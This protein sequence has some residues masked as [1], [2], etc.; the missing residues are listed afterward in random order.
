MLNRFISLLICVAFFQAC[1]VSKKAAN[2]PVT[3]N[4]DTLAVKEKVPVQAV[5]RASATRIND[6]LHTKLEVSFD[7]NKKYL[8]GKATLTIKPYFYP[9][10]VLDL[11]ARGMEIEQVALLAGT[12]KKDLKYTY[13]DNVI[14][15]EL[16]KTYQNTEEYRIFIDYIAK[17][18][19]LEKGGSAAITDDKGLYFIN[20]DGKDKDK[21]QQIWTQGETESNSVWMPTIDKPNERMTQEIYITTEDKYVTLSNGELVSSSHN[22][23]GT[24]TDYW[25]MDLP[26]APYLTMMA[27]GDF[28][29]VKDKWR[30]KEVNYYVEKKYEPY[31][32]NTFGN[33]P[34]M[35][36]FFSKKLG[37]DYAW[38][39]YSQIVVRDYVSGAMENT[40]ATLHGEFMNRTAK[41]LLYQDYEDVIS[42]ELFHQWFGDLVT[43]ES[44]SNIPLNESFATYGEYLWNEYKYGKDAADQQ[45]QEAKDKYLVESLQKKETLIRFHYDSREDMFDR[46][47]Y[48]KGGQVLHMLRNYVGDDAFFAS[49]KLYLETNEF[50]SVEI[51]NLRLAFEQVTGE[52]LN[53]FFNQWFLSPG[54]PE[55]EI[56]TSYDALTK[57]EKVEI[58]Q[59]QDLTK[60]P[61][62]EIPMYIDIYSGGKVERKKIHVEQAK[63]EFYFDAAQQPDL[64]NVDAEKML[65]CRK[66]DV[67]AI[68]EW[69]FQY[70]HAPLYL[71]RYE[72]LNALA[73]KAKDSLAAK[74]ILSALNDKHWSL[75][76]KAIS[77]LKLC[78]AGNEQEIKNK[79]IALANADDKA[80][81]REAAIDYLAANYK[82]EDLREVY[83]TALK[84]K[85]DEVIGSALIGL[86]KI[87]QKAGMT[88]AKELENTDNL[89][90][91][92][93]IM[94]VYADY[95]S[96]ENNNFFI[97]TSEA[98]KTYYIRQFIMSYGAFLKRLT[99]YETLNA[100]VD[101]L[102]PYVN[103]NN[104]NP[105]GK[106]YL[107]TALTSIKL[108]L[109]KRIEE[110]NKKLKTTDVLKMDEADKIVQAKIEKD[111]IEKQ[112][113]TD[114][115]NSIK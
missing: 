42:H 16:D 70:A 56:H 82:D 32:R 40:T 33:T 108:E 4:L 47:S 14:H 110:G 48:E 54:H 103:T 97:K 91:S 41:E 57:K 49:L 89:N 17:P 85:T 78:K 18:N 99:N 83:Q 10:A 75:R 31:A 69:A 36:E 84:D 51:H 12:A 114:S 37:V 111:K 55:L 21:P 80:M 101:F 92:T 38:N 7:W 3:I 88:A 23:D 76:K 43:T 106:N 28:A 25:K 94:D 52:D 53:W 64:V 113:I 27:I 1:S 104:F 29:I 115:Y 45:H 81:V 46:H 71:D 87:D 20:A 61:V 68:S 26:H 65:L 98:F 105:Y 15:I 59:T 74:T 13:K 67:K 39:K 34:E 22:G 8:F 100:G 107:K 30:D 90:L 72:A 112:R 60:I 86:V 62:F 19:E 66:I 102:I 95:G 24:H 6:I 109:D 79:L 73:V 63:Q 5:Y 44:W 58:K 96:E 35:M 9:T 50:K 93:A 2:V 11:N 77:N